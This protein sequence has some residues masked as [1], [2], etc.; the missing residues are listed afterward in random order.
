MTEPAEAAVK[1]LT[2]A[3]FEMKNLSVVGKNP[4]R[5]LFFAI[6]A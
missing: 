6:G 5:V 3:G 1:K 4:L 2:S